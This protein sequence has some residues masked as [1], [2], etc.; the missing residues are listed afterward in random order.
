MKSQHW[1]H[2]STGEEFAADPTPKLRTI[3]AAQRLHLLIYKDGNEAY[4][5]QCI[6][7]KGSVVHAVIGEN[8]TPAPIVPRPC[9]DLKCVRTPPTPVC[10]L[11]EREFEWHTEPLTEHM[12]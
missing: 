10:E 5:W 4:D 9:H 12:P 2:F 1:G 7:L 6:G 11:D 3:E 8:F